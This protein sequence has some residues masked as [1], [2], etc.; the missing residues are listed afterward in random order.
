[1]LEVEQKFRVS[2]LTEIKN[3]IESLLTIETATSLRQKDTYLL[4]PVRDFR[5]TD[6]AL[7]IRETTVDGDP[8]ESS[9]LITWKGPRI[10]PDASGREFKTRREIELPVGYRPQDAGKLQELLSVLGFGPAGEVVKRRQ[11]LTCRWQN[12][13]VEIALDEVQ[14]LGQF[15]EVEIFADEG[16]IE[17]AQQAVSELTQLLGLTDP[18]TTSYRNMLSSD[19]E[20][21]S[22]SGD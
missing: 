17:S 15:A 13:Q 1:M 2:D 18:I 3:L 8:G 10:D 12:W 16:Q 21:G 20:P 7:R 4:H 11:L 6:E 5:E 19:P 9:V 22:G 14:D